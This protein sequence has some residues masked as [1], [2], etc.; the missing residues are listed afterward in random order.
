MRVRGVAASSAPAY[1]PI[2]VPLGMEV[3]VP[4]FMLNDIHSRTA[5]FH[6]QYV[7][8]MFVLEKVSTPFS[9]EVPGS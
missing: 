6:K 7:R 9:K 2:W 1:S 5:C 3:L 4:V 8:K